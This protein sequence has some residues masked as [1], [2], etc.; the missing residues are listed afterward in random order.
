MKQKLSINSLSFVLILPLFLLSIV[1]S[2]AQSKVEHSLQIPCGKVERYQLDSKFI[3]NRN[4]D[5]WIPEGYSPRN[6][7]KVLYMHD[8][9]MLYD[10]TYAWNKNSWKVGCTVQRLIDIA[11][12]DSVIVVGIWN[13]DKRH[14]EY[15]PQK[16]INFIPD[17]RKE[18]LFQYMPDGP[19]ADN[20]LKFIV[21]EL[22]PFVDKTFS[23]LKGSSNTFIAGSS[24]GGLISLYALCEYPNVFGGAACLST[25]WIGTL[26]DNE[27]IPDALSKYIETALP[28]PEKHK[29]YFDYGTVG[30]DANYPRHQARVDSIM[31]E[32]NYGKANW[33][34]FEFPEEDHNEKFWAARLYYPLLFLLG[35]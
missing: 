4:V 31:K 13:S 11:Q 15:F 24:M 18:A 1:Q 22:K 34:T 6:K 33:I 27:Y 16:A 30:L 29:I 28:L 35:S 3:N 32:K 26:E 20:Y 8:G 25:H 2:N 23:T 21:E 10:G 17:A 9:Q 12:I 19:L 14:A 7:Y 5:I